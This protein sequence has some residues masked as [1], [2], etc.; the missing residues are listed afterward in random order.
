MNCQFGWFLRS[1]LGTN[2]ETYDD[3]RVRTLAIGDD[4]TWADG[5]VRMLD[6]I[7]SDY[8]ILLLEDFLLQPGRKKQGVAR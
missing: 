1:F 7:R 3:P 4:T 2:F 5:V 8:V 6:S